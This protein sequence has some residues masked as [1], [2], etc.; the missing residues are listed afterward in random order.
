MVCINNQQLLTV[1]LRKQ[2]AFITILSKDYIL[3]S[4]II[5][6]PITLTTYHRDTLDDYS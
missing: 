3:D 4:K 5:L 2:C 1:L 6:V